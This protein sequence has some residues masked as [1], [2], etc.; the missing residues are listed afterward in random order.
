MTFEN[1]SVLKHI[2]QTVAKEMILNLEVQIEQDQK[3]LKQLEKL[4]QKE[5]L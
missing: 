5:K 3:L 1:I 2:K 4:L